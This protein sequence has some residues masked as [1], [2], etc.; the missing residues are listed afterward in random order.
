MA[1]RPSP[2]PA[3]RCIFDRKSRMRKHCAHHSYNQIR[4]KD[5]SM[6]YRCLPLLTAIIVTC[7]PSLLLAQ[8]QQQLQSVTKPNI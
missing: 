1:D 6:L 4:D 2:R 3:K 5:R 7:T 8:Q